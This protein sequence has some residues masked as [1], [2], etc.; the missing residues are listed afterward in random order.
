M[1]PLLA[2]AGLVATVST[3]FVIEGMT[4]P[5]IGSFDDLQGKTVAAIKGTY[6]EEYTKTVEGITPVLEDSLHSALQKLIVTEEIEAITGPYESLRMASQYGLGAGT[7]KLS[8]Y[9]YNL[10]SIAWP[11]R[12]NMHETIVESLSRGTLALLGGEYFERL[13]EQYFST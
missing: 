6:A 13:R 5:E 4:P 10:H 2:I 1:L 11:L 9:R 8:L 12:S 3:K 7:T